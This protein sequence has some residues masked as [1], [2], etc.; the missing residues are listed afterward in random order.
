MAPRATHTYYK[1]H[2]HFSQADHISDKAAAIYLATQTRVW[3]EECAEGKRV[4]FSRDLTDER[5]PPWRAWLTYS[6]K[7]AWLDEHILARDVGIHEFK[8]AWLVDRP[9]GRAVFTCTTSDSPESIW[10]LEPGHEP[11]LEKSEYIF[12]T[13]Y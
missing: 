12:H 4:G 9:E 8:V 3:N 6:K 11:S 1:V 10:V 7:Q 5:E 2:G 13:V